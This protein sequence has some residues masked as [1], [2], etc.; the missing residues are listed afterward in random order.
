MA[1]YDDLAEERLR[2][3]D[4]GVGAVD[5]LPSPDATI[6]LPLRRYHCAAYQQ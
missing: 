2:I 5:E 3:Y 6:D 4:R 1:V